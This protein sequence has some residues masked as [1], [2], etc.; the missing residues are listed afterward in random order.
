MDKGNAADSMAGQ[1]E[2]R[3]MKNS[4]QETGQTVLI[5]IKALTKA[6]NC[7]VGA[8][9]KKFPG[10]LRCTCAP[11]HFQIRFGVTV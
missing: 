3:K 2:H 10:A 5:I 8:Q 1:G 7:T 4:K 9:P 6:T 11:P